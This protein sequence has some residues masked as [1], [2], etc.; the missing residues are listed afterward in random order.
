VAPTLPI[1]ALFSAWRGRGRRPEVGLLC[2]S[3]T[4]PQPRRVPNEALAN[5]TSLLSVRFRPAKFFASATKAVLPHGIVRA[6]EQRSSGQYPFGGESGGDQCVSAGGLLSLLTGG[7][8]SGAGEGATLR[9][10]ARA[11]ALGALS[12]NAAPCGFPSPNQPAKKA[13]S[14][15]KKEP[16]CQFP[17]IQH[18]RHAPFARRQIL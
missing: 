16:A 6:W 2:S 7:V 18:R 5:K 12:R 13:G 11:A 14:P 1:A 15:R 8:S 17:N 4:P 10:H 3:S 9:R